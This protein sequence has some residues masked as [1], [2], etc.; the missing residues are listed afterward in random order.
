MGEEVEKTNRSLA[1]ERIIISVTLLFSLDE[2][3]AV[4]EIHTVK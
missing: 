2:N 4:Y 1:Q 3:Q